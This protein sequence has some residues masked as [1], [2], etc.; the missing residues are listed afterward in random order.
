[1]GKV[2]TDFGKPHYFLHRTYLGDQDLLVIF[3]TRRCKYHCKFCQ[4]P[5][6]N[7]QRLIPSDSILNQF[8]Y[9]L[10]ELKHSLSVLTRVTLANEGSILDS[11]TFPQEALQ[12]ILE[13]ITEIRLVR[14]VVIES[15]LEFCNDK[16]LRLLTQ[17]VP[18]ATID[19]LTGFETVNVRIRDEIL[20][21]QQTLRQFLT[22]LDVIA[23][24][25]VHLTCYIL[26]KPDPAMTDDEAMVEARESFEFLHRECCQR[27]IVLTIRLN[28]M[29]AAT[30]SRWAEYANR[31]DSYAPLK[32]FGQDIGP[33]KFAMTRMNAVIHDMEAEVAL[34]NTIKNPAFK[35]SDGSLKQFDMVTANPMW[36]QKFAAAVYENDTYNRFTRGIPPSSSADWGW[37]QH[38]LAS[39]NKA[40]KMA[41]VLDTGA[42]SRGS[43]N[44]GSNK[45]RNIRKQ[46]VDDDLVEAVFLLPDN[47]FYNTPAQGIIL[48]INRR[49]KHPGEILLVNGTKLYTK[50]RPKNYLADEHIE[51]MADRYLR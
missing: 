24:A 17:T 21:K 49:K 32:L 43:G 47:I 46:F 38:M 20:G 29:Y 48:V 30:G 10:H 36:N 16:I 44:Q 8:V 3:N 51:S 31:C 6:K 42:V 45:E 41:I 5:L 9:V 15:R 7:P 37:V 12:A 34:G 40:G 19:I 27:N 28:P 2:S 50:G 1:M 4:L 33:E 23:R 35:N 18:K 25:G 11:D 14:T 39:L 22:G 26:F 13:A